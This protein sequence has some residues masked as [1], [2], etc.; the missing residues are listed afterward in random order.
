[1]HALLGGATQ[2]NKRMQLDESPTEKLAGGT[3]LTTE[4]R[5]QAHAYVGIKKDIGPC[6][7]VSRELGAGGGE[8]ARRAALQL[9]W[10]ILDKEIVETLAA[11][12]GTPRAV[13]DTV[14]EKRVGWLADML[15]G[16][17]EGH[18]YSQLTYVQRLHRLLNGAAERGEVVIV[19]RGATFILPRW[20]GFSVRIIAPFDFRVNQVVLRRGLSAEKARKLVEQSDYDRQAFIEKYFHH[21]VARPHCHNLIVNVEQMEQED[22]VDLIVGAVR[23]WLKRSRFTARRF[24]K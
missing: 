22:A 19:G 21:D 20:A 8:I 12:Y 23:S 13:L 10:K 11:E 18:G 1:L 24:T 17:I 14:D 6:L 9:D 7:L 5:Q 15:Y 2:M 16:W 4:Q 3:S